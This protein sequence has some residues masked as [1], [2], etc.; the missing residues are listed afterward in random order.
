MCF[1]SS[2]ND[3]M[4]NQQPKLRRVGLYWWV[5]GS[6]GI[7]LG[8]VGIV[9]GAVGLCWDLVGIVY[10]VSTYLG[11]H[12]WYRFENMVW[13]EPAPEKKTT[14]IRQTVLLVCWKGYR[15]TG[16]FI[17]FYL[18]FKLDIFVLFFKMF[19]EFPFYRI[20]CLY[21][22]LIDPENPPRRIYCTSHGLRIIMQI[23][24]K[25]IFI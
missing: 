6:C 7:V 13:M 12:G 19:G 25:G 22:S 15:T 20:R 8:C 9:L 16:W 17:H 1:F 10:L 24:G 2:Q 3:R 4:H 11:P 23:N 21:P 5:L 14:Y 18:V